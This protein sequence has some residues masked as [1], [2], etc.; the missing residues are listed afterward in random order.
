MKT[1]SSRTS[2]SPRRTSHGNRCSARRL[3]PARTGKVVFRNLVVNGKKVTPE[4]CGDYFDILKGVTVG[5][6]V[7]FE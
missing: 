3:D 6:E 2:R 1:S 4:N 5:K 7:V